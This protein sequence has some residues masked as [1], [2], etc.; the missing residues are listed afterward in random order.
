MYTRFL[1]SQ[2]TI[3]FRLY[4][5]TFDLHTVLYHHQLLQPAPSI[6]FCLLLLW[7][8]VYMRGKHAEGTDPEEK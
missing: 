8:F 5:Q 7:K 2:I 6:S 4:T 3:I 1:E